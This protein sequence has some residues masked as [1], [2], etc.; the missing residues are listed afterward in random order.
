MKVLGD[1]HTLRVAAAWEHSWAGAVNPSVSRVST[2]CILADRMH[3]TIQSMAGWMLDGLRREG[4]CTNVNFGFVPQKDGLAYVKQI[5]QSAKAS[6]EFVG[7]IAVGCPSEVYRLLAES[8]VPTLVFG[9]LYQDAPVLASIDFD[10]REAARL[11]TRYLVDRGHKRMMLVS[12]S[13]GLPGDHDFVDG[14]SDVLTEVG[15]PANAL[16][17]RI[18]SDDPKSALQ[19]VRQ[20]L[21]DNNHPS[22]LIVRDLPVIETVDSVLSDTGLRSPDDLEIV[23]Q[24]VAVDGKK[25]PRHPHIVPQ[26]EI[27]EI[28]RRW[29]ACCGSRST[30]RIRRE[31]EW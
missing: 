23:Y 27:D 7:L 2:V 5:I 6:T 19:A 14:V 17:M 1:S 30:G 29:A 31:Q 12:T 25:S 18:V 13:D 9:S 20:L 16:V 24:C 21:R 11:M 28:A 3:N 4:D 8:T 22:S 15:L 10:N 26:F